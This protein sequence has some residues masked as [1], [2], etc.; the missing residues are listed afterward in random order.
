MHKR[1]CGD[2]E[3]HLRMKGRTDDGRLE[4]C[5]Y[6]LLP[7]GRRVNFSEL[8]SG[9]GAEFNAETLDR[10][11]ANAIGFYAYYTS[12]NRPDDPEAVADEVPDWCPP[13]EVCDA[14]A[15]AVEHGQD[16][17]YCIRRKRGGPVF[18]EE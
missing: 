3:I 13:A 9:V 7:D 15:H 17:G 2:L 11:A 16:Y 10:M 4:F 14:I 5:G 18:V 6:F 12:D 1:Y 8:R